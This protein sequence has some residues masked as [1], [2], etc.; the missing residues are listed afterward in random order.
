MPDARCPNCQSWRPRKR[1]TTAP[2]EP[3]P[4]RIV[5]PCCDEVSDV[6]DVEYRLGSL[7]PTPSERGEVTQSEGHNRTGSFPPL[8]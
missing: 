8:C 7:A 3:F 5:C 6:A 1:W 2:G 4:F